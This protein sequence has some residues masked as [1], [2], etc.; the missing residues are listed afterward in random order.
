MGAT[1]LGD[2]A[3]HHLGE[4]LGQK[5]PKGISSFGSLYPGVYQS[6]RASRH[7]AQFHV[8]YKTGRL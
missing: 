8:V 1:C 3:Q 6:F 2:I 4:S 5:A 7:V